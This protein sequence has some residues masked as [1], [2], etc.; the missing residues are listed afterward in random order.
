MLPAASV[1]VLFVLVMFKFAASLRLVKVQTMLVGAATVPNA[2]A[3]ALKSTLP[4]LTPLIVGVAVPP[5]AKPVQEM[6]SKVKPTGAD[7]VSV[8]AEFALMP[9][10]CDVTVAPATVVVTG[11]VTQ[12]LVPVKVKVPVPPLETLRTVS[13]G[14]SESMGKNV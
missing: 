13:E 12:P 5:A 10:D 2:V 3:A 8:I 6:A 14:K 11:C 7:S 9:S 4:P 1:V